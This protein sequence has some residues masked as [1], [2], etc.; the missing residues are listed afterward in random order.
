MEQNDQNGTVKNTYH[1]ATRYVQNAIEKVKEGSSN[2][3]EA[4]ENLVN[5]TFNKHKN[6]RK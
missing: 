3:D 6:N 2:I 1:E 4:T 5:Q